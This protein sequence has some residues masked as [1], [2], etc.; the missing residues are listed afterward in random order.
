MTKSRPHGFIAGL[1]DSYLAIFIIGAIQGFAV[2]IA[3]K[4]VP[5][6]LSIALQLAALV[7]AI[8]YHTKLSNRVLWLSPGE[9]LAGRIVRAG[10]K[11]WVN[12]Y[13]RNRWAL[14]VVILLTLGLTHNVWNWV[15]DHVYPLRSVVGYA[16][17]L[18]LVYWGAV[19]MGKGK[20]WGAL[21]PVIIFT[22]GVVFTPAWRSEAARTTETIFLG[23]LAVMNGLV[24]LAYYFLR[25]STA[26]TTG[27]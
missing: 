10:A 20:M 2:N 15:T 16:I 26:P 9:Q 17:R 7:G 19:L 14:F 1:S 6:V 12:P 27:S 3:Q 21:F 11:E 23:S 24:V 13:G 4:P 8:L 25:K 5:D 22:I 18:S